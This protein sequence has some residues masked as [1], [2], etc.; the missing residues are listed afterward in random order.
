LDSRDQSVDARVHGLHEQVPHKLALLDALAAESS[1]AQFVLFGHSI[2]AWVVLQMMRARPDLDI[3]HAFC[4][5]PFLRFDL[6]WHQELAFRLL[7]LL[8][9]LLTV[10]FRVFSWFS[11]SIRNRI[12]RACGAPSDAI[13]LANRLI[14]HP[15]VMQNA[16]FMGR[17]EFNSMPRA[18]FAVPDVQLK[19]Q[20]NLTY[21]WVRG[22]RWAPEHQLADLCKLLRGSE[23]QSTE[24][25]SNIEL[26]EHDP[27]VSHAFCV[28][29]HSCAL[30]AMRCGAVLQRRGLL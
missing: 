14:D 12:V 16:F 23:E 4:G 22:D 13:S 8:A 17:D 6:S 26:L 19:N 1:G 27:P 2:G 25:P 24:I 10:L 11:L 7:F 29:H 15:V 18:Q 9:P 28:E 21:F 5:F 30:V 3:Q 20:K